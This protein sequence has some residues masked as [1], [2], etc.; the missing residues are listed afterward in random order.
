MRFLIFFILIISLIQAAN[1]AFIPKSFVAELN[2][3]HKSQEIKTQ[4]KYMEGGYIY[5]T[6]FD[7]FE[8]DQAQLVYVCNPKT[9]Y[10][11]VPPFDKNEKGELTRGASNVYCY[12]KVFEALR[13]G[14]K[15][16]ELY[17]VKIENNS[18]FLTFSEKASKQLGLKK[19]DLEFENKNKSSISDVS[20]MILYFEQKPEPTKFVLKSFDIKQKLN[21]TDFEFQI[22]ENTNIK[23]MK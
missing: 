15:N 8:P 6:S 19:I 16:N 5:Y 14:L 2:E 1:A 21:K 10:K 9:T 23:E 12:S 18:A 20:S 3:V 7:T 11:Y 17:T 13:R 22:P 4:I